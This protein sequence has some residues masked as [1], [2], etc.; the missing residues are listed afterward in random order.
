MPAHQRPS[1]PDLLADH[2]YAILNYDPSTDVAEFWNPHGEHFEP[3]GPPGIKYGYPTNHG[4][5]KVPLTE[6]YQLYASFT[7]EEATMARAR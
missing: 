7:I 5:F 2:V 6:A 3:K 1:P 4:R